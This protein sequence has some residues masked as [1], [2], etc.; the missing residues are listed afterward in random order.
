M[1]SKIDAKTLHR[2]D[3]QGLDQVPEDTLAPL[4]SWLRL[5]YVLCAA[6]ATAGVSLASP[7]ILWLLAPIALLAALFPVHPFDLIYNHGLRHLTGTGPFPARGAPARFA[8]GLGGVWLV[9]TGLAFAAGNM[10]LGMVLGWF[11]VGLASLVAISNICIPSMVFRAI[12]G[13]PQRN[14]GAG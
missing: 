9:G 4:A 2:L 8:C 3:I 14:T 6:M 7:V 11:L 12:F 13:P 5:P 10:M 1:S